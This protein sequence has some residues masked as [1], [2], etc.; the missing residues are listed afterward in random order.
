MRRA[1]TLCAGIAV[2]LL[3][4]H[5]CMGRGDPFPSSTTTTVSPADSLAFIAD[6]NAVRSILD[7]NG[8]TNVSVY[9]VTA[10]KNSR[11]TKL[12]LSAG[13]LTVLP[14]AVGEL[15]GLTR[16]LLLNNQLEELPAELGYLTNLEKL[17]I[18]DNELVS[19]PTSIGSLS[20]LQRLE[21]SNN[22]LTSLPA[23]ITQLDS[24]AL[25][26]TVANNELCTLPAEIEQWLDA[27]AYESA[28]EEKQVCVE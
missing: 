15:T 21:A 10:F 4:L 5:G 19:L 11:V 17:Y 26:I 14:A 16:L 18:S 8:L 13:G 7:T 2:F 22:A 27:H 9:T 20:A 6:T 23:T 3:V 1:W 24:E 28:W 25:V 12:D